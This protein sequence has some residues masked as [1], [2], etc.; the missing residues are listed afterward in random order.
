MVGDVGVSELMIGYVTSSRKQ[1]SRSEDKSV[2]H[3]G[4]WLV[5]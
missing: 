1:A 3:M 2:V 5:A 4:G